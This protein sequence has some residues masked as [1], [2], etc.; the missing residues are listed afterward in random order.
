MKILDETYDKF[1][2]EINELVNE[3]T[4]PFSKED[5]NKILK[6]TTLKHKIEF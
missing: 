6:K 5:F 1:C 3:D 4:V 2:H